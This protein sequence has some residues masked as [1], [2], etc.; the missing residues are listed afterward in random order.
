[1]KAGSINLK[2]RDESLKTIEFLTSLYKKQRITT[3]EFTQKVNIALSKL[4]DE[5]DYSE[6]LRNIGQK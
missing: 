6:Y 4:S 1:M 2:T 3:R 5:R